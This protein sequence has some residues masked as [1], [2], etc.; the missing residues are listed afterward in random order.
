MNPI[1]SERHGPRR[2]RRVVFSVAAVAATAA[3]LAACAGSAS[4]SGSGSGEPV[5]GGTL[6]VGSPTPNATPEPVTMYDPGSINVVQQ[7]AEYLFWA[8]NDGELT[9]MLAESYESSEDASFWTIAL[10]DRVE[11]NDGTPLTAADVVAS[12][13]R[14]IAPDSV[15]AAAS[16][17]AGILSP[18]GATAID[19]TTIEFTLDRPFADFPYLVSS[20]NYNT[21]ILPADY[22]GDFVNDP[23]GTGP[24]LLDSYDS[25][26]GATFSKNPDY[27][28]ADDVKLDGV[29][30]TFYTD[31]SAM[32]T[33]LLSRAIDV[34][35]LVTYA[36]NQPLYGNDQVV[37]DATISGGGSFIA[38]RTDMP[39][40]DDVRV[41]Q[42]LALSL[43]RPALVEALQ[44][45]TGDVANDNIFAPIYKQS[46]D[47]PQREQDI[48]EAKALLAEAGYPDGLETTLSA[49]QSAAPLA[50]L[51]QQMAAEAG[52][53]LELDLQDDATFYDV[54]WLEAPLGITGWAS[55]PTAAQFLSLLFTSDAV[56]N[57]AHWS[58][59]EFDALVDEF[60]STV[61][62]AARD[63]IA[64]QL[65]EMMTEEVPQIITTWSE[66]AVATLPDV[67]GIE[68]NASA[69]IRLSDAWLDR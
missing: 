29:D 60:E 6:K 11:F 28:E 25:A 16:S 59:P 44:G 48:D 31:Y 33:A 22:S 61:D 69:F 51:V 35:A 32:S 65:A 3:L 68:A 4:G 56:W 66:V 55:R 15:S 1:L 45:G 34:A 54:T 8:E 47:V 38:P 18:G 27:R 46:I 40:W 36:S 67:R 64:Q 2:A 12:I 43:D 39:P 24:Y 37:I 57:T 7:V 9:P 14:L 13:E 53:T 23:I 49:P 42:A 63:E 19:D 62:D 58:N 30:M 26:T 17:F 52:I 20:A 5:A 41:R 50:Q 10:Q 21:I